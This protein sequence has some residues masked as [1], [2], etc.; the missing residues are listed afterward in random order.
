MNPNKGQK[1]PKKDV[2][3]FIIKECLQNRK[4]KT[5]KE[6]VKQISKEL[7]K[8]DKKYRISGKRAR[9]IALQVPSIRVRIKTKH[10][11][12]PRKCPCCSHRLKKKYT[13][14]L[15]GKKLL[16]ELRCSRCSYKGTEGKWVPKKYEF[17]LSL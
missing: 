11:K 12:K 5:Q 3:K 4:M 7:K 2:V 10:G 14:T 8:G 17:E 1:I 9:L 13:R 16:Y 6:L 15:A